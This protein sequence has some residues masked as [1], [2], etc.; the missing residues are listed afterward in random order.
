M[1]CVSSFLEVAKDAA[2]Q[3]YQKWKGQEPFWWE[4][5]KYKAIEELEM[6]KFCKHKRQGAVWN[7][8]TSIGVTN[9]E[10]NQ[11]GDIDG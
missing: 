10:P 5:D 9:F 7:F 3:T 1:V 11:P 8:L 4:H 2:K 6:K